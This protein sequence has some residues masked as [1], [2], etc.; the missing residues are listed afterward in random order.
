MRTRIL[1]I[2]QELVYDW[3]LRGESSIPAW[4]RWKLQHSTKFETWRAWCCR[5]TCCSGSS[6]GSTS[7]HS[8]SA[9]SRCRNNSVSHNHCSLSWYTIYTTNVATKTATKSPRNTQTT[10]AENF[11]CLWCNNPDTVSVMLGGHV[12][13]LKIWGTLYTRYCDLYILFLK[14]ETIA[15]VHQ[16]GRVFCAKFVATLMCLI[17]IYKLYHEYSFQW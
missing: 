6:T 15:E 5:L 11:W 2:I 17:S 7:T 14:S 13:Y 3:T 8:A 9:T 1:Y 10:R 12:Q 16:G 4:T